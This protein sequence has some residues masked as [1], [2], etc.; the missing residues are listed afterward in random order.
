MPTPSR[1][2]ATLA[3][4]PI[5][6]PSLDCDTVSLPGTPS[7]R[8]DDTVVR[9]ALAVLY[10]IAVGP[11]ADRYAPRFL[12][13]ERHGR[14][15]PG[16]HWP[17]LVAPA[18]WAFYRRLWG[19]GVLCTLLPVAGLAAFM[20][21]APRLDGSALLFWS[22][23][24][25]S[26]WLLPN[27][28]PALF[29]DALV[30]LRARR[31]VHAAEAN[32]RSPGDA[33]K[34]LAASRPTSPLAGFVGGGAALALAAALLAPNLE[35]VQAERAVRAELASTLAAVKTLQGDVEAALRHSDA[36]P[37]PFEALLTV[38]RAGGT[39]AESVDI[40]PAT[41][42]VRVALGA[43]VPAL[44]GKAIL[45][46]PAIDARDQV[47]WICVAVDIPRTLLPADCR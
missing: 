23:A 43:A 27:L 2:T 3:A 17:A 16:W 33:V 38:V 9:P 35:L 31:V 41:G 47:R 11:G 32:G 44:A 15:R 46:A 20:T 28:L 36:L 4:S 14:A 40:N 10:R 6:V 34:R 19:T 37:R 22:A 1:R 13:F 5:D 24:V 42:R 21:V 29:A 12:S 18:A 26:V 39:L 7:D 8:A 30:Y 25:A 45:L